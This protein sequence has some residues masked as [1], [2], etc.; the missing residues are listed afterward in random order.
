MAPP[1]ELWN[2][3]KT[4]LLLS[5]VNSELSADSSM[6]RGSWRRITDLMNQSR[7]GRRTYII[8]NICTHYNRELKPWFVREKQAAAAKVAKAAAE[9]AAA[10]ASYHATL[11][12]KPIREG[13]GDG[14]QPAH[15]VYERY[16]EAT[17]P[18]RKSSDYFWK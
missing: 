3:K 5:L 14:M 10:E 18:P 8:D 9:A 6:P 17:G 7:V 4:K 15:E 16:T 11:T 12:L 2:L 1:G 13:F